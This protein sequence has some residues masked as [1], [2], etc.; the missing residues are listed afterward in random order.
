MN[1]SRNTPL[2]GEAW[3]QH[4][5]RL[6]DDQNDWPAKYTFKFIAP[7][8]ELDDLRSVF[9]DEPVKVRASSKGN[10]VS[11]TAHLEMASSQEV[12]AIYK[13]AGKIDGVISL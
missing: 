7:H 12:V 13:E 6:L 2:Q 11:V 1:F 5:R 4:F 10:Y 3:W 9:G 8:Q